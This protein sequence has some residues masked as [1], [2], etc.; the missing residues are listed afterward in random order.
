[1]KR[2]ASCV[3]V[4]SL[5]A[6]LGSVMLAGSASA[7]TPERD[8]YHDHFV[9]VDSSFCG[10]PITFDYFRSVMSTV[11]FNRQGDAIAVRRHIAIIGTDTAKGVTLQDTAV[12]NSLDDLV[13]GSETRTGIAFLVKLPR[14]GV[15]SVGGGRVVVDADGNVTFE[16]GPHPFLDGNLDAYCAAFD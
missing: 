9:E 1:M 15:I 11:F 12:H 5:T 16:A 4:V 10:F 6:F 13:T 8:V 2:S 7:L 14:G 3:A